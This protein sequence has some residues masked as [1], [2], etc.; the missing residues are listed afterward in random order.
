MSRVPQRLFSFSKHLR[1]S[2]MAA[3]ANNFYSIVAGVGAGTGMYSLVLSHLDIELT[4]YKAVLY[5]QFR[6]DNL[7]YETLFC[8]LRRCW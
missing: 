6:A 7:S 4:L 1:F 2:N 5:V 3:A 8:F